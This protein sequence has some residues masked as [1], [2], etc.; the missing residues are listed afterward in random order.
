MLMCQENNV[1]LLKLIVNDYNLILG[2]HIVG[3]CA[4]EII[5]SAVIALEYSSYCEDIMKISHAHPS[6]HESLKHA[7][8]KI[9]NT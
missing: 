3:F 7:I 8:L 9:N 1:G 6:I 4:S 5:F 2:I